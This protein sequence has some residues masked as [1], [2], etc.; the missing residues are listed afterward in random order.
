LQ[1]ELGFSALYVTHDQDEAMELADRVAVMA[2]GEILQM[3]PPIDIYQRPT[4]ARVA[5]FVGRTNELRGTVQ[6]LEGNAHVSVS[7]PIGPALALRADGGPPLS[8]GAAA[9]LVCRPERCHISREP[10]G[11]P[12]CW[13][14]TV[15][16]SV[17]FGAHCEDIVESA[18][19]VQFRTWRA[20]VEPLE[21]GS[22]VW[23][24]IR[25]DDLRVS[26]VEPG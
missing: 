16:A 14:A 20:G 23:L 17:F 2:D 8:P 22:Q 10:D 1:R 26:T 12:N 15:R 18:Q 11:Q 4:S 24:S 13:P 19:G 6:T 9:V 7:T 25:P 3:G 21:A 5:N